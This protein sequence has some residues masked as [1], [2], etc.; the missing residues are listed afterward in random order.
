MSVPSN[1]RT[2]ASMI[3]M[4]DVPSVVRAAVLDATRGPFAQPQIHVKRLRAKSKFSRIADLPA[5]SAVTPKLRGV[6]GRRCTS[7]V[8]TRFDLVVV[9]VFV[10]FAVF[11]HIEVL[12]P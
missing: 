7:A 4:P 11:R 5:G 1:E 2:A 8:L 9:F 3:E 6:S 10:V 12:L